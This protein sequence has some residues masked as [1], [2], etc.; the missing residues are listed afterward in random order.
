MVFVVML[1][2]IYVDATV[3]RVP[4]SLL[5]EEKVAVATSQEA[6]LPPQH[7]LLGNFKRNASLIYKNLEAMISSLV[8]RGN[9]IEIEK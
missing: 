9:E 8:S 3:A 6:G 1:W 2:V 4:G 5:L 7:Q